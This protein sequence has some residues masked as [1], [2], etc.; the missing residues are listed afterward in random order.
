MDADERVGGRN[1][2][3]K[4]GSIAPD[5]LLVYGARALLEHLHRRGLQLYLASGTDEYAVKN[6]AELLD[7]FADLTIRPASV[8]PN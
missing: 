8:P 6:E 2:G 1:T 7:V 5:D 3:L 4:N